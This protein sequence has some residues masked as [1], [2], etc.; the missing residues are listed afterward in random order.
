[1]RGIWLSVCV[2]LF[3]SLAAAHASVED[4]AG[5]AYRAG[6]FA[7]ARN[8]WEEEL[9]SATTPAERAR[10]AY[11][12]G[13]TAYR[14]GQ[15][16][17]A[18]GWY[19]AALR[20]AP[21]DRDVWANLE[22]ARSE[23]E[24]EPA[25]RGDLRDTVRRHLLMSFGLAGSQ[26]L[27]LA[28]LVL[29]GACFAGEAL[30]GGLFWRRLISCSLACVLLACVPWAWNASHAAGHP[31]L[32]I[33]PGGAQARSEPSVSAKVLKRYDPGTEL[34]YTDELPD[35]IKVQDDQ[36]RAMWV[37]RGTVFDLLR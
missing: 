6:D 11:N 17:L 28:T 27:V 12:I 35:W 7:S 21:R 32:V 19:T 3:T 25:D 29:L 22:L 10:L 23:A 4:A 18:I 33:E 30:R 37:A 36:G 26:W 24:L 1:M 20:D 2:L 31:L 15:L 5:L 34:E 9:T 14:Q 8:L 13:N 16:H